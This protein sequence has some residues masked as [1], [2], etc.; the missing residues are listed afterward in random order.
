MLAG[1]ED[2]A[3]RRS[4]AR[5]RSAQRAGR[6]EWAW[7]ALDAR[8]RL[9]AAQGSV[10]PARRDTEA[11]LAMLEETAAKLPRDLREVFWDDPRRRALARPTPPPSPRSPRSMS[12]P[13]RRP[14]AARR[15]RSGVRAGTSIF[16]GPRL[17]EDRLARILEITR[18]LATEHDM[19]ASSRR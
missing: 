9:A 16:S 17:A 15:R 6:R 10:A 14:R 8:A 7:R 1:D 13:R 12:R 3:R 19:R 18:E 2:A 11:A 4:T 5:S